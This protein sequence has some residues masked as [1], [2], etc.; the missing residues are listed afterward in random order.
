MQSGAFWKTGWRWLWRE[1]VATSLVIILTSA[2]MW[3]LFGWMARQDFETAQRLQ[4]MIVDTEQ[5]RIQ[6]IQ[7]VADQLA[8]QAG[9]LALASDAWQGRMDQLET[10]V[11]A[12]LETDAD[13]KFRYEVL[14]RIK[15]LEKRVA[16]RTP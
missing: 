8:S 12:I 10:K 15:T 2:L 5:E 7:Q 13:L 1:S 3:A 16:E 11:E 4:R 6:A 9:A 14:K